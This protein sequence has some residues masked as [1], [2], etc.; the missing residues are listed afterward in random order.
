MIKQYNY[1]YALGE[2]TVS[3]QVDTD[4]FTA[5][6]ADETLT[7]FAWAHEKISLLLNSYIPNAYMSGSVSFAL[8][9]ALL[10]DTLKNLLE[11]TE[12]LATIVHLITS[13]QGEAI[14][15]AKVALKIGD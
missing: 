11:A 6:M 10:R 15:K 1:E 9:A 3:F 4:V 7:F 2:A 12:E 14:E 13:K 5:E 8:E